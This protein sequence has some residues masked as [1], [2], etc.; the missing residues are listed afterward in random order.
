MCRSA[1]GAILKKVSS[2]FLTAARCISAI[3]AEPHLLLMFR[4]HCSMSHNLPVLFRT[5]GLE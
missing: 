3:T 4:K 1:E 2:D 5:L